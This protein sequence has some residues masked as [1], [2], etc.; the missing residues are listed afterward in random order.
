MLEKR[1]CPDALLPKPLSDFSCTFSLPFTGILGSYTG[2]RSKHQPM[3]LFRQ[4][5]SGQGEIR[6]EKN[7]GVPRDKEGWTSLISCR[8][9]WLQKGVDL[10]DV[11]ISGYTLHLTQ[12][13]TDTGSL[14]GNSELCCLDPGMGEADRVR[15]TDVSPGASA[16]LEPGCIDTVLLLH[17]PPFKGDQRQCFP[18][19]NISALGP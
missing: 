2:A 12:T 4:G 9:K 7:T 10:T 3:M 6:R 8:E 15:E 16:A 14:K 17:L 18:D 11:L 19:L 13:S 1:R 5:G